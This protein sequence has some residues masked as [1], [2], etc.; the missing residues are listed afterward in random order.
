MDHE[1]IHYSHQT[2]DEDDI[3]AVNKVLISD[4]LTTGPMVD[5]F[6]ED[7]MKQCGCKYAVAVSSGTAALHAAMFAIG[8]QPGD[9]VIVPT[10]TFASTA[11]VVALMGATPIFCDIDS[12]TLLINI[13]DVCNKITD[14]TKAI[15]AVDYAGQPCDYMKLKYLSKLYD[16]IL[17]ADA[18][19]SLGG[20]Y[21][22]IKV[23]SDLADVS[24]FSFHAVKGVTT[25]EG[26]M[27]V[28]ND[29]TFY[30]RAKR[31]RN[32]GITTDHRQRTER[33]S[34]YYEM[35]DLGFNYRI[36]D[37]QCA[38]GVSQLRKLPVFIELRN[39]IAMAYDKFFRE[40]VDIRPLRKNE[41]VVHAYHLYVVKCL[42]AGMRQFMFRY[43]R[44]NNI[45][46][47]VH[48]IPVHLHPY[49]QKN[50]N[51]RSGMLKNAECVYKQILS[52]PIFPAMSKCQF[53]RITDAITKGLKGY[54]E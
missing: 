14:K 3:K 13:D 16:L 4:W 24:V 5:Q 36:T 38:L 26:G 48:Y 23:G 30:E 25:G 17:V 28:T 45:G 15:I 46:V 1:Y 18:C 8:L 32:H 6:E 19:H 11:N 42:N 52:L 53:D 50:Y 34:W 39:D 10:I 51:T 40:I 41:N 12:D 54:Y 29:E 43:L 21:C 22:N 37:I 9:E 44:G 33:G 31:F 49:Y 2:I 47:N 35:V 20:S 7:M 27:V